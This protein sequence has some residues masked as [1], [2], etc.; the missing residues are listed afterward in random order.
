VSH[1]QGKGPASSPLV[2]HTGPSSRP[3]PS[4]GRALEDDEQATRLEELDDW[5]QWLVNRYALDHRVVPA[6][7]AQHGALLEELSAL[8]TAWQTAYAK[9]LKATPRWNG[10]PISPSLDNASRTGSPEQGAAPEST[11]AVGASHSSRVPIL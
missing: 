6:C 9:M 4:A 7:W 10:T 1:G 2:T 11:A 8:H 3:N 5:T